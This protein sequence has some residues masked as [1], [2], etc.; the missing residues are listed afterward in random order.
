MMQIAEPK[1]DIE[2]ALIKDLSEKGKECWETKYPCNDGGWIHYRFSS[3][4]ELKDVSIFI[5]LRTKKN[6]AL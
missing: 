6:I 2:K 3:I 5:S 4:N 1:N